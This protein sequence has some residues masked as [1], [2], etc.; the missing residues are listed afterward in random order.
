MGDVKKF[1]HF[2][3]GWL[4]LNEFSKLCIILWIQEQANNSDGDM[5]LVYC[6]LL[7]VLMGSFGYEK[8]RTE[9]GM[10]YL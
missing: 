10:K 7:F 2:I 1:I 8:I 6:K 5:I 3:K 9:F 4:L